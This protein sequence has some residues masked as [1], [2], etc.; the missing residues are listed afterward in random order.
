MANGVAKLTLNRPDRLNA[1][2][3]PMLDELVERLQ[4]FAV[5]ASV[6]CVL[7]AGAGK[8]FCAG[9]DLSGGEEPDKTSE[10]RPE[11]AAAHMMIHSQIPTLL[12]RM[13]KPT[14]AAIRGPAAGSGLLLA[15][16][17]DLRVASV[18]ARFKLAFATAGRCGD[19]GGSF[20]LTQLLGSAKA[21]ELYL[22]DE[23]FDAPSALAMGLVNRLVDDDQLEA[24][25]QTIAEKLAQGPTAAFAAMKRNL[26][27]AET[28]SF[29]ETMAL[30]A[31]ANAQLS[32]SH[33]GKEAARAF[34]EKR[35][36]VFRGY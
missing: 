22:L 13:A 17:C 30:E 15:A 23:K 8:G 9:Y 2:T 5:D 12:R 27:N 31:T 16:A 34:M 24:E 1:L 10:I 14:V 28:S 29:E 3:M 32:L 4:S 19:P 26:N 36:P 35:A 33:D 20:L 7:I 6:R 18:T 25:S 21:R 11:E